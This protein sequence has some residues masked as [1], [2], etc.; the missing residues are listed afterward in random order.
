MGNKTK[1]FVSVVALAFA[2]LFFGPATSPAHAQHGGP[3]VAFHGQIPLPHG[4]LD[5]YADHG[6]YR[7]RGYG[8]AYSHRT[9]RH[10]QPYFRQDRDF[11]RYRHDRFSRYDRP[12]P[13]RSYYRHHRPY[14]LVRVFVYDPFPHY[15]HRRVYYSPGYSAY[16]DPYDPY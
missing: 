16:C 7:H 2:V 1:S 3:R 13:G 4:S 14:R 9:Y 10:R 8:Q 11:R 5:V 12:Y 6:G 15:V